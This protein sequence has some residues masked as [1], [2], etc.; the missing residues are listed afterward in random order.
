MPSLTR[1][2]K[3]DLDNFK[4]LMDSLNYPM[5]RTAEKKEPEELKFP[6]HLLDGE[7]DG[8]RRLWMD[9]VN[10]EL[11]RTLFK[12]K[13]FF[14]GR[15]CNRVSLTVLIRACGGQVSWDR[16]TFPCAKFSEDDQDITHQVVDR[17]A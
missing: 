3:K 11:R 13:K 2:E 12:G 5:E 14:L 17:D 10:K 15:E 1:K 16:S 6:Q 9:M 8:V 7:T 4:N